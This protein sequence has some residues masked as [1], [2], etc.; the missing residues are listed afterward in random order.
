M[1]IPILCVICNSEISEASYPEHMRGL[2]PTGQLSALR[3]QKMIS[4]NTPTL[5]TGV[6]PADLPSQEFLDTVS[7]MEKEKTLPLPPMHVVDHP[8]QSQ[9]V[10]KEA[11][12]K[13]I[14]PLQLT[15][16]YTGT[17]EEGNTITTLEIDKDGKHFV[18]AY[19]IPLRKQLE[20]REVPDLKEKTVSV[21]NTPVRAGTSIPTLKKKTRNRTTGEKSEL[22]RE[23]AKYAETL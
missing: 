7:E 13:E 15:Y 6:T 22:A 2:H 1:N 11:V 3:K 8:R 16:T 4:Q 12:K 17:D 18:V 10:S 19:S 20:S 5:P 14:T 21:Q 23:K 9:T